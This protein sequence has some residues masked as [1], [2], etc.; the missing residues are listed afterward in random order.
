MHPVTPTP[1]EQNKPSDP[2]HLSPACPPLEVPVLFHGPCHQP[3]MSSGNTFRGEYAHVAFVSHTSHLFPAFTHLPAACC[4]I[5]VVR[6]PQ[7]ASETPG[8]L[9]GPQGP[10]PHLRGSG[11]AGLRWS[12]ALCICD[13]PRWYRWCTGPSLSSTCSSHVPGRRPSHLSGRYCS[14]FFMS[15]AS[16]R[17]H[18]TLMGQAFTLTPILRRR[19]LSPE[20]W[21]PLFEGLEMGR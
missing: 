6:G 19:N 7:C 4:R 10:G 12:L 17:P 13:R 16:F 15:S 11:A 8:G 20:K 14:Q 21:T 1:L 2:S 5:P 3:P 9:V 18:E